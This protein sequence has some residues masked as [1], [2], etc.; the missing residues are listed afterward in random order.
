MKSQGVIAAGGQLTAEAGAAMLRQGGNAVDAAI[1]AA[2]ASFIAEIGMVHWGGSGIAQI[3]NPVS[4][5]STIVDFF[6][7]MPG[8]GLDRLPDDLNFEPV[9]I[10][11]GATTQDFHLGRASVSVPTNILGLCQMAAQFGTLPLATLLEP[12]IELAR[13]GV[14]LNEYQASICHLLTPLYTHTASMRTIFW[15]QDRMPNA[16]EHIFIPHLHETLQALKT[17]GADLLRS[18]TLGQALVDDQARRGGLV[19]GQDLTS[20]AVELGEPFTVAYRDFEVLLPQN[21]SVGGVLVGF[22]LKL[23][24]AFDSA[25]SPQS[26]QSYQLF[27][28]AMEATSRARHDAEQHPDRPIGYILSDDFVAKHVTQV[29]HALDNQQP[30]A[31]VPPAKGPSH[32]SHISV[33][34]SNGMAVT[35]T[36]TAGESAGYVVPNS[37]FI[38]NNML[39]E[40]DLNPHGWHKHPAG[41]RLPTM[42]T[43]TLL[44]KNGAVVIATGSGG[45]ERIRSAIVQVIRN[46]VDFGM[47]LDE[48]VTYPRLHIEAGVMQCEAGFDEA[49]V[50]QLASWGY[51]CNRWGNRSMYF[52]GAHSVGVGA[53]GLIPAADP[54]RDGHTEAC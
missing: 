40:K 43:P 6:T 53:S 22:T 16:G 19:T 24:A 1:A 31:P 27:Y 23:L 44:M 45:S 13:D 5:R 10:D 29:K 20:Y 2:F 7:N 50:Q 47:P 9:T 14:I 35:L 42:M 41:K 36:T 38:P 12:A 18:G 4:K 11:F 33:I 30:F 32:T 39:G 52:G 51:R 26:V 34:D 17:Q 25:E 3:Y 54:R 48:A 15:Q 8:L 21:C 46:F 49:S 37:G 28:E